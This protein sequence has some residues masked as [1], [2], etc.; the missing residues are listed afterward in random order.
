MNNKQINVTKSYLPPI[1]EYV[2]TISSIW[3]NH[4]LTNY[5]PIN[6]RLVTELSKYLKLKNLHFVSNGT[7][8][9]QLCLD[10]LDKKN[11]E[12][13]TTPF[14][15][16]ATLSSIV[17]QRYKPVFVDIREDDFN[18]NPD[19][20][21]EKINKNTVAIMAVHCFGI[22]CD[23]NKI[24]KIAKKY[25]IAVIYDAA[26]SFGTKLNNKS[27]LSYGDLVSCSF[28]ATKVFHTI[29]GGL[30]IANNSKYQEKLNAIKNF[31]NENG[32]TKYVGIN[33]K[34]SEFHAAMGVCVLNHFDEILKK[35]KEI[36]NIYIDNLGDLLLRPKMP[37]N[38]T[39]NYIYFPVLFKNETELLKV[40][41]ELNKLNIYPRRYFYP[42]LNEIEIYEKYG[43]T[44]IASDISKR[45]ACLPF[46]TYLE[47]NDIK[48]I[49]DT[50]KKVIS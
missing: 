44:P 50:I 48:I 17:W 46:D 19:L 24:N 40:F 38:F 7:I 42:A 14:T 37:E 31:G 16:V 35:R 39:Y 45:I 33:A 6:D 20:I 10:T 11:G 15:F 27:V 29:E 5:G 8:S 25:K 12:I 18:I 2:K 28:H 1:N 23:V 3:D 49:C 47:K 32:E 9:L 4:V 43:K 26:H 41:S 21:E 13:I 36:Y 30:C 22:P 34:N